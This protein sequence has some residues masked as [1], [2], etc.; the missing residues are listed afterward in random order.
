MKPR[1]SPHQFVIRCL[2]RRPGE[3]RISPDEQTIRGFAHAIGDGWLEGDQ[4]L[5]EYFANME[6]SAKGVQRLTKKYGLY[7]DAT[8]QGDQKEGEFT[9]PVELVL[10]DQEQLRRGWSSIIELHADKRKHGTKFPFRYS[11]P[12]SRGK[13]FPFE[14]YKASFSVEHGAYFFYSD[15]PGT[16]FFVARSI[17]TLLFL[18]FHLFPAADLKICENPNCTHLKFFISSDRR[19]RTC[20]QGCADAMRR[21]SKLKWW[22]T[23]GKGRSSSQTSKAQR[24]KK[25]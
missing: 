19:Q 8:Y 6:S 12:D 14:V 22:N 17:R 25:R 5:L 7:P 13:R 9:L 15:P 21:T 16:L 20:S 24:G 4:D 11:I 10:M 23:K 18:T 1:K 3:V 2:V